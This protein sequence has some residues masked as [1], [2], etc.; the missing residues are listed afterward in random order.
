[1]RNYTQLV[2]W[3]KH[4]L[5]VDIVKDTIGKGKELFICL[6]THTFALLITVGLYLRTHYEMATHICFNCL[7]LPLFTIEVHS[8][9]V[10]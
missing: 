9:V 4:P 2:N 10:D 1:M 7:P 5:T 6:S 3:V 8:F